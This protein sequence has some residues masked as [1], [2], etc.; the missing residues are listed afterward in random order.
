MAEYEK[1][2]ITLRTDDKSFVDEIAREKSVGRSA[3]IRW[4]LDHYRAFLMASTSTCRT[5]R[6]AEEAPTDAD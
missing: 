2:A 4:A 1:I 5:D 6:E 3:V